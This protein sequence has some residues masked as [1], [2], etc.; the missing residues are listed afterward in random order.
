[1]RLA[2]FV[3]E[4]S[5]S[6]VKGR[7]V[8]VLH[9]GYDTGNPD[10]AA[11]RAAY[12][13]IAGRLPVGLTLT[14][15]SSGD[16]IEDS[17]GALVGVWSGDTQQT[18]VG[19]ANGSSAAGVGSCIGWSTGAIVGTRKL[20]GRTFLSPLSIECYDLD[21]TLTTSALQSTQSVAA[22]LLGMGGLM[23]WHRPTSSGAADGTSSGVLAYR[24]ADRVS[25]LGSRRR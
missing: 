23:I 17:T 12:L 10:T 2:R 21:G 6:M 22:G 20:R 4:W 9:Y 13:P 14:I 24:V 3:V 7:A 25:S 18:I 5:G 1:M 15:P 16:V 8:N 11:L 19:T